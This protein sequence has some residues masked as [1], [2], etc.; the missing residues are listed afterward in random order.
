MT[1]FGKKG[2]ADEIKLRML[3]QDHPG[4]SRWALNP[5][6]HVLI[7]DSQSRDGQRRAKGQVETEAE[8]RVIQPQTKEH[9]EPP[10]GRG[11]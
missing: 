7:R 9:P 10:A 1:L 6:K 5:M 3:S 8:R 4:L 2:F 11:T